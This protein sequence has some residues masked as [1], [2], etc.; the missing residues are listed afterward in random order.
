MDGEYFDSLR[1]KPTRVFER[2]MNE[3][4]RKWTFNRKQLQ[5]ITSSFVDTIVHVFVFLEVVVS[6]CCVILLTILDL[7]MLSCMNLYVA[8][9]VDNNRV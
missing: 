2:Y 3:H 7:I 9:F 6:T 5:S 1:R 4:C 8:L